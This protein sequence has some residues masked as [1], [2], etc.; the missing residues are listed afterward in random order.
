MIQTK[1]ALPLFY[2]DLSTKINNKDVYK[3][4]DL[5]H[6]KVKIE[7]PNIKKEIPQCKRYQGIG[8]TKLLQETGQMRKIQ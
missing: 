5:L 8:H 1:I 6:C 2:V 3:I 4:A 7:P